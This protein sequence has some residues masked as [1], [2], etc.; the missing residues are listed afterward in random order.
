MLKQL[1]PTACGGA[2]ILEAL[3]EES[4]NL[5]SGARAAAAEDLSNRAA[6]L[7][8]DLLSTKPAGKPCENAPRFDQAPEIQI[9]ESD[10]KHLRGTVHRPEA[11]S[12]QNWKFQACSRAWANREFQPFRCFTVWLLFRKAQ[13]LASMSKQAMR[14]A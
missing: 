12:L 10:N 11:N 8:H 14:R 13:R 6:S 1:S 3:V 2:K 4:R 9:A 5:R 7:R